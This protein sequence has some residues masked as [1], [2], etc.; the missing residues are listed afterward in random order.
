MEKKE[1]RGKKS[2]FYTRAVTRGG[3]RVPL[4]TTEGEAQLGEHYLRQKTRKLKKETK[5]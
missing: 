1:N 3:A 2:I 4:F 5:N